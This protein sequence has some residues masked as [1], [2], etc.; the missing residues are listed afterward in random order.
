[1]EPLIMLLH[2]AVFAEVHLQELTGLITDS[3]PPATIREALE[4]SGG[5]TIIA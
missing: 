3:E 4:K 5:V 1:M 2:G